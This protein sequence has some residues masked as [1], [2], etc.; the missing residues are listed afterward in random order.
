MMIVEILAIVFVAAFFLKLL[1]LVL[2]QKTSY[3]YVKMVLE[4]RKTFTVLSVLLLLVVGYYLFQEVSQ[5]DVAAA[6]IFILLLEAVTFLTHSNYD[7][8]KDATKK[9]MVT[10]NLAMKNWFSL[11]LWTLFA[12]WV[13]TRLLL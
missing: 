11:F 6:A 2:S 5:V 9:V 4:N 8:L 1:T 10:K 12:A 7:E 13:I 3:K